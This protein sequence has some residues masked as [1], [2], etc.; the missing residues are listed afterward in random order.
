MN[1]FRCKYRTFILGATLFFL[2]Y[3]NL[4]YRIETL[5]KVILK[6]EEDYIFTRENIMDF[7]M[8]PKFTEKYYKI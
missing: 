6:L 5:Y 4:Q 8:R 7:N 1:G 2:V 3:S